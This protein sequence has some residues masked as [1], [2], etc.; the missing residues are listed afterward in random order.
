MQW[1]EDM[2]KFADELKREY[3]DEYPDIYIEEEN[4]DVS[5]H[6]RSI[7]KIEMIHKASV[8]DSLVFKIQYADI[9]DTYEEKQIKKDILLSRFHPT[10]Y[11][12][13]ESIMD[14]DYKTL[15]IHYP[16][17]YE[18]GLHIKEIKSAK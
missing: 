14:L 12:M 9:Q 1:N 18:Y 7:D 10:R 8:S 17:P 16:S 2:E 4:P 11:Q 5:V 3:G 15:N 13:N 6:R